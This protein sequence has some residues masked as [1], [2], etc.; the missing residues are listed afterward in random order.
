MD[1][2]SDTNST[3][4][5]FVPLN[6]RQSQAALFAKT[7]G[8]AAREDVR[9]EF[10]WYHTKD[11]T[12][13]D[14][15]G[16]ISDSVKGTILNGNVSS[17][18]AFTAPQDRWDYADQLLEDSVLDTTGKLVSY[19]WKDNG[20]SSFRQVVL[21]AHSKVIREGGDEIAFRIA[22]WDSCIGGAYQLKAGFYEWLCANTC[23]RGEEVLAI[24]SIHRGR[25]RKSITAED[26]EDMAYQE[27]KRYG[28]L[29]EATKNALGVYE[30]TIQTLQEL[31]T[32]PVMAGADTLHFFRALL[33]KS[34]QN[35]ALADHLHAKTEE[36]FAAKASSWFDVHEVLTD[37]AAR[38]TGT[39]TLDNICDRSRQDRETLAARAT[40]FMLAFN[41]SPTN[42]AQ[43]M[44]A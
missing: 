2:H 5:A 31:A 23:T 27:Q 44:A 24:R 32:L 37:Y 7:N 13:S 26:R 42:T 35:R 12:E 10:H 14:L 9:P 3:I 34:K 40:D 8:L 36:H 18:Y 28:K 21:P 1:M 29:L 15:A 43:L 11:G 19:D 39:E 20:A 22:E 33:G 41:Q 17:K 38:G 4:D 16:Y 6:H 25:P 30:T